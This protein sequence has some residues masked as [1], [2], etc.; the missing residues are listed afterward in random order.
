[1]FSAARYSRNGHLD[2]SA[3][4]AALDNGAAA[5]RRL[6]VTKLWPVRK[7]DALAKSVSELGGAVWS[8]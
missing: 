2:T 4:D 8:R 7:A 5:I 3:L 1:V 6:R